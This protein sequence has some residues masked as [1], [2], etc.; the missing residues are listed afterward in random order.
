MQSFGWKVTGM[1]MSRQAVEICREQELAVYQG[2][3]PQEMFPPESFDVVTMWHVLEHVPSPTRTL[4]QMNSI[5]KPKGKLVLAVPN[6]NSL[7]A[8]CFGPNWFCWE[9]PRHFTHFTKVTL[10]KMLE[11]TQFT[12]EKITHEI[13]GKTVQRSLKYLGRAKG[14]KIYTRLA[15]SRR[16]S[17]ILERFG[18]CFFEPDI[19]V[20][21][22]RKK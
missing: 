19:M 14:R 15:G 12:V 16:L 11:K 17:V 9:L 2:V 13:H 18:A 20:I 3:N 5:L 4:T 8:R 6:T 7:T 22:A 1:D 10:S 21:H